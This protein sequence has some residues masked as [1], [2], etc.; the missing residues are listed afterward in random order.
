MTTFPFAPQS[1]DEWIIKF[2]PRRR[3]LTGD[4]YQVAKRIMDLTLV[5]LSMPL[6][7]PVL[8]IIGLIVQI[9]SPGAP[10]MFKQ[11]RTV[12]G[13]RFLSTSWAT[14]VATWLRRSTDSG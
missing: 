12:L 2:S 5:L 3:S 6:W 10:A 7:A 14:K 1:V 9:T 4:F 8:A 11:C 13:A